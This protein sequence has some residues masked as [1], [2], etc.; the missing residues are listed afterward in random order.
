MSG[1]MFS[2]DPTRPDFILCGGPDGHGGVWL[3]ASRELAVTELEIRTQRPNLFEWKGER[4]KNRVFL[5][6]EMFDAVEIHAQSYPEAIQALS[7]HWGNK[8]YT[9]HKGI[10]P[11]QGELPAVPGIDSGDPTP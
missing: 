8:W 6:T 1:T 7:E 3:L 9:E 4:L 11:G 5:K 2:G 10:T